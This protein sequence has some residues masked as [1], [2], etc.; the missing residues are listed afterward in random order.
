MCQAKSSPTPMLPSTKLASDAG[1]LISDPYTYRSIVGALLYICHTRPDILF[2]V[3]RVAQ[4]MH[5]PCED[6]M[7]DVRLILRYLVGTIDYGLLFTPSDMGVG[8]VVAFSDVDWGNSLDDQRSTSGY[9]VYVDN[10]LVAWSF[11]RH[12]SVSRSTSEAE[13]RSVADTMSEILWVNTVLKYMGIHASSSPVVWCD[14]TSV[15]SILANPVFHSRSKHVELDVHFVREKV[16]EQKVQVN[17][18]R[19]EYQVADGLT[20]PLSKTYFQDFRRKMSAHSIRTLLLEKGGGSRGNV[21]Q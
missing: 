13:Y 7:T 19:A 21:E 5:K 16:V 17:Y 3:N 2:S 4:F 15:V 8:S 10:Y 12:K 20:K 11:K 1:K 6:H 9:Y 14:N 18:V